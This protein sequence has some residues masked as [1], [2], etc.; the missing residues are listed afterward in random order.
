MTESKDELNIEYKDIK[1]LSYYD[2][3]GEYVDVFN[4]ADFV[5]AVLVFTDKGN[6]DR[7]YIVINS[8]IVY[9]DNIECLN[10]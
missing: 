9:L 6:E 2:G 10:S 8:E 5:S 4:K 1:D 3:W 7:E